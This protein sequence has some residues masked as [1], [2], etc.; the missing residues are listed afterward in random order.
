[1]DIQLNSTSKTASRSTFASGSSGGNGG[2]AWPGVAVEM[3]SGVRGPFSPFLGTGHR[4]P[5]SESEATP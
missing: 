3:T 5:D 1:M 2:G 4:I